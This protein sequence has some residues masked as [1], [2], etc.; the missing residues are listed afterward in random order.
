MRRLGIV[1]V[2]FALAACGADGEPERPE[3]GEETGFSVT[4]T[5]KVGIGSR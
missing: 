2:L 1:M 4:G 3:K 5:A